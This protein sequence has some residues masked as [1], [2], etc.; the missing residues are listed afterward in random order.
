MNAP[1]VFPKLSREALADRW[2]VLLDRSGLPERF[3]VDEFGE[4]I[5][6]NPPKLPDNTRRELSEKVAADL[7]AGAREVILVEM[8]G[9]IRFLGAVGERQ[10]STFA[11]EL[12]LPQGTY[13]R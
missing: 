3:E 12:R 4:L 2:R 10:A 7:E 5:G 13:P 6:L 8:G 9:R 11:L 1:V